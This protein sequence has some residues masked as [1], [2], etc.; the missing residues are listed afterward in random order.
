MEKKFRALRIVSVVFKVLAWVTLV[1]GI[2][3]ALGAVVLGVLSVGTM[4]RMPELR[5]LMPLMAGGSGI[6][7]GILSALGILASSLVG[8]VLLYAYAEAI[9]LAI[10]IEQNTRECAYHLKGEDAY[11]SA[12]GGY[13][14]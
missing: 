4:D 5:N 10:A 11:Q 9:Y 3:S 14:T 7:A 12:P 8:F 1:G 6:V 13:G 2:L